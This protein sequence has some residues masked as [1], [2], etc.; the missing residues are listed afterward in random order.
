MHD[1]DV[2]P[3]NLV[4]LSH[5]EFIVQIIAGGGPAYCVVLPSGIEGVD[6][7]ENALVPTLENISTL[8]ATLVGIQED[9]THLMPPSQ[10]R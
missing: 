1:N 2:P 4:F 3:I 9:A 5:N 8:N 10:P 6:T 7:E